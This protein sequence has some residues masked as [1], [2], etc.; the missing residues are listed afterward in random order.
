M[1]LARVAVT[2]AKRRHCFA[3]EETEAE[4][5][6]ENSVRVVKDTKAMHLTSL[7]FTL[8]VQL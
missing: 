3:L 8:V 4:F 6:F 1:K 7:E 5:T 2:V